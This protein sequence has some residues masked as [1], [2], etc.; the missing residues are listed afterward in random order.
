[1]LRKLGLDYEILNAGC[2]GMAGGF[3][4]EAGDK[5]DVSI[6]A[7]EHVLLPAVRSARQ[8]ALIISDGF[9]CREQIA[10]TADRRALH[11]A[12]VFH[13][14][15]HADARQ[16]PTGYPERAVGLNGTHAAWRIPAALLGASALVG[17][18]LLWRGN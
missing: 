18:G 6:K 1:L 17:G 7:G 4:F 2:R 12:E 15:L 16:Q 9:S 13:M 10:Q 14:T 11:L 5:Y 3:G 8:D